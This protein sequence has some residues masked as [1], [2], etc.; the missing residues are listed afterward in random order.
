LLSSVFNTNGDIKLVERFLELVTLQQKQVQLNF[1]FFF[2]LFK[3]FLAAVG[4]K[5][6]AF[7]SDGALVMI[8]KSNDETAKLKYKMKNPRDRR[9]P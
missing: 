5:M 4:K 3:Q 6:V 9:F 7:F 8:G 2:K 1:F